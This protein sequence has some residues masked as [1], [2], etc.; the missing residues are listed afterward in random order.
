MEACRTSRAQNMTE[1]FAHILPVHTFHYKQW[2]KTVHHYQL[3]F[4]GDSALI[5][6]T[7]MDMPSIHF[8]T[9][10][11]TPRH[12]HDQLTARPP[13]RG[14]TPFA[15]FAFELL[16]CLRQSAQRDWRALMSKLR[17]GAERLR[18]LGAAVFQNCTKDAAMN[19]RQRS[20]PSLPN[21]AAY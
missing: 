12:F 15:S 18:T 10:K 2:D 8:R 13:Q 19:H 7:L 4:A 16:T 6:R 14:A 5:C 21:R 3:S 17:R 11:S 9:I 1:T 20:L